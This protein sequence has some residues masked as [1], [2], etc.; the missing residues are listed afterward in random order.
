MLKMDRRFNL[1]KAMKLNATIRAKI[2]CVVSWLFKV[3]IEVPD[4]EWKARRK[5]FCEGPGRAFMKGFEKGLK[6]ELKRK[7]YAKSK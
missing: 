4:F 5:K 2:L 1:K 6:K 7:K 3:Q